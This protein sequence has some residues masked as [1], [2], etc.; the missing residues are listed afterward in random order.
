MKKHNGEHPCDDSELEK[1]LEDF[2]L[3][4][5]T[6]YLDETAFRIDLFETEN[7]I[8]VE[9]LL[10]DYKPTGISVYL[11]NDQMYIQA[12]PSNDAKKRKGPCKNRTISFPFRVIEQ[13]VYAK[14]NNGIL[15]VFVS[16]DTPGNRKNRYVILSQ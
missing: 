12:F 2:F 5:L 4:P 7:E 16:K 11:E 13:K 3:N 1:W 14:F 9:A 10:T 15:E 6:S 8:I